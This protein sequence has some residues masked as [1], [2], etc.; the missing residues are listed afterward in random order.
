M[1]SYYMKRLEEA[2]VLLGGE[3]AQC[4]AKEALEFDHVNPRE[5]KY[6]ITKI[7]MQ[8]KA[9]WL[10]ELRKCQ[11]LCKVHH[12]EKT[13]AHIADGTI[14]MGRQPRRGQPTVGDG[15]RLESG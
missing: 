13:N 5:K 12:K 6:D 7:L 15:C 1:R 11:L 3:C 2:Q 10:A 9:K 4:G 8:A 14:R